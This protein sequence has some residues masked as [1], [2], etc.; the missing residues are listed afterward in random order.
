[1]VFGDR[2]KNHILPD[3]IHMLN[4]SFLVPQMRREFGGC[5]ANIAYGLNLLGD[6][7]IVMATVGQDFAP[8][9]ERMVAQGMCLKH[10]TVVDGTFTAQAF[11]TTDLDD[12]Q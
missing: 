12:N 9:K 5:A 4:V 6:R 2:F 3:K 10:V 8:Y 11:I 1:M 7:G